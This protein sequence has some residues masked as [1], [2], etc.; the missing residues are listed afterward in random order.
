MDCRFWKIVYSIVPFI[1]NCCPSRK[2]CD[3]TGNT[4]KPF[5]IG[6]ILPTYF[7]PL[8]I[9]NFCCLL[10]SQF[11]VPS[12][13]SYEVVSR[14]S[15]ALGW[16]HNSGLRGTYIFEV[17]SYRHFR[18]PVLRQ[19]LAIFHVDQPDKN[20]CC[21]L[22]QVLSGFHIEIKATSFGGYSPLFLVFI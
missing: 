4:V 14:A 20:Q 15:R 6:K 12:F 21:L 1:S 2:A 9:L 16:K 8:F 18:E 17:T 5:H 7:Y 3:T 10:F 13:Q 19:I 11:S 22:I